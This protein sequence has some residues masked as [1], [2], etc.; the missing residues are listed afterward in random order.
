MKV[1]FFGTS[2]LVIPIIQT[3]K[4]NFDLALVITTESGKNDPVPFYCINN[5]IN[6]VSVSKTGD[7]ISANFLKQTMA[8]IGVVADFGLILPEQVL[9]TFPLGVINIH[10]SL[11]PKYRGPSPVQS[12]ILN[13]DIETGVTII[14]LDK[15]MD[16][17]PIIGQK[18][19]KIEPTDTAQ[20]LYER[21]FKFG[22][23]ILLHTASRLE[24]LTLHPIEQNHEAATF[25]NRLTRD[26][27]LIDFNK[28]TNKT[29]F[30]RMVR[31]YFPWPGVWSKVVLNDDNEPKIVKF[32]PNKMLQVEGK[33]EM[34]YKDFINGYPKADKKLIEFLKANFPYDL[35][36]DEELQ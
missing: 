25:T 19:A 32:L 5:K 26:D 15:Y 4:Q 21:L 13:G 30:E 34:S 1:V 10:P 33:R 18:M 22:G 36:D 27:G 29:I 9:K 7:L 3:L 2:K 16:H 8:E 24:T 31:A 6:Y 12:A 20:D 17:G 11:L 23:E 35:T 14:K 28:A